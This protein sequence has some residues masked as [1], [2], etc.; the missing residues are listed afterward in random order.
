LYTL[1]KNFISF[2][3][4]YS[5]KQYAIFQAGRLY[6]DARSCDL[7]IKVP[8]IAKH[9][10]VA[11]LGRTYLAYC[12]CTRRG[13]AE[14]I[15]IAAAFTGGDSD[16]L[17]VG[18]NGIFYDRAGLD[19]DATIV[20]VLDDRYEIVREG[21]F[22]HRIIERFMRT[23]VLFVCSGNT[24]RSPMSEA[25]ARRRIADKLGVSPDELEKKGI[26]VL[27]AGSFALPGARATP[28]AVEALKDLGVDLSRHRSRPLTVELIHQADMIFPMSRAHAG[29]VASLVPS[30]SEKTVTL[31]PND[32][33]DDP[34]GGELALYQALA[35]QLSQFIDQ[36][37]VPK[38]VTEAVS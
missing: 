10:I 32:D 18:R 23:T 26:V 16:H 37:V 30:A 27:S 33:I 20:R 1:L 28:Q 15:T 7:C 13:G 2:A 8:D 22:D 19:W 21:V 31:N 6:L 12:E 5:D 35:K 17:M 36:H 4:F 3:D 9:A 34:I 25:I 38:V 11:T 29:A 24:C 14:K